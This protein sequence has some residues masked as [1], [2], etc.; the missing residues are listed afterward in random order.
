MAGDVEQALLAIIARQGAKSTE[1]A[2]AYL[3]AVAAAGR[4]HKDVWA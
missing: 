3:D 1:Q 2:R 4:Y